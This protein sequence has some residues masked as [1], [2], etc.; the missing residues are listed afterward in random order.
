LAIKVNANKYYVSRASRSFISWISKRRSIMLTKI[1]VFFAVVRHGMSQLTG[2][3]APN[4]C[5]KSNKKTA[6]IIV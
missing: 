4:F 2:S 5:M 6:N 1:N 3:Q